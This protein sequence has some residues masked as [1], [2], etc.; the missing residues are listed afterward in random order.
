MAPTKTKLADEKHESNISITK[1]LDFFSKL[2]IGSGKSVFGDT[3][4]INTYL[5]MSPTE[6]SPFR[7][8]RDV[9]IK[10]SCMGQGWAR[11]TPPP[12]DSN[13]CISGSKFFVIEFHM[14]QTGS[15]YLAQDKRA[16]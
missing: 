2:K 9:K 5:T 15:Q 3:C 10:L 14:L 11:A 4:Q 7:G 1:P 8:H 6:A 16:I 13:L 12:A